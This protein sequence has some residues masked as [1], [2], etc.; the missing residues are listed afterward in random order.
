MLSKNHIPNLLTYSRIAA[1]PL[2]L[3]TW[4]LPAP[5]G[6]WLPFALTA[7]AC[8]TD[9]LDGHLARKWQVESDIGRLLDPNADKILIAVA[10]I[11]LTFEG[12]AHPAAVALIMCRELFISGLREFMAERNIVVH[13]T[14]LAKWKTATQMLATLALLLAHALSDAGTFL[15][16]GQLLLWLATALTLITGWQYIRGSFKHIKS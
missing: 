2:L 8:L 9:F 15:L 10:L 3:A 6:L 11:L 16:A 12:L 5:W 14:A 4:H 13:V 1:V 7:Y